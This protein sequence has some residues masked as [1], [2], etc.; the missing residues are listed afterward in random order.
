M[1]VY[2]M[3]VP[4]KEW[5]LPNFILIIVKIFPSRPASRLV[6]FTERKLQTKKNIALFLLKIPNRRAKKL[7]KKK[8]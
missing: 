3:T 6:T 2:Y 8:R 5:G 1:H 4:H 7:D